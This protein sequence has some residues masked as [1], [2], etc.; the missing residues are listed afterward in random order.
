MIPKVCN[1][2]NITR[3]LQFLKSNFSAI[4]PNYIKKTIYDKKW[5]EMTISKDANRRIDLMKAFANV[6]NDHEYNKFFPD[7]ENALK[8]PQTNEI[9]EFSAI[10]LFSSLLFIKTK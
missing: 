7:L 6:K 1:M 4:C 8:N 9:F 3:K 5:I 10:F 2:M